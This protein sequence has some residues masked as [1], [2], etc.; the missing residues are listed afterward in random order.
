MVFCVPHKG[1]GV[2]AFYLKA[3]KF[4][5]F[6]L[7]LRKVAAA[8]LINIKL[9]KTGGIHQAIKICGIA[10]LYGVDC[11]MGCMLE[12]GFYSPIT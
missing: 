6:I 8:D 1:G 10:S 12:S 2:H 5:A 11:M 3:G 4:Q 7:P 9:M